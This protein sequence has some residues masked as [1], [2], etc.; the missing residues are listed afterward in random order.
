M[1]LGIGLFAIA[2]VLAVVAWA[3]IRGQRRDYE[4][5][6]SPEDE[7]TDEEFRRIEF[8]DDEI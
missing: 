1:F 7:L 2:A 3:A 5:T 8:G 6:G 4:A